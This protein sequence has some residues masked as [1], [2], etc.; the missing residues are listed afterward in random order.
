MFKKLGALGRFGEKLTPEEEEKVKSQA[1][2]YADLLK[3]GT[4]VDKDFRDS[5]IAPEYP[6]Y[7]SRVIAALDLDSELV[8]RISEKAR[9]EVTMKRSSEGSEWWGPHA[10]T[11]RCAVCG[12]DQSFT[13][14]DLGIDPLDDPEGV[15]VLPPSWIRIPVPPKLKESLPA[16]SDQLACGECVGQVMMSMEAGPDSR[17]YW[18]PSDP[19]ASFSLIDSA[20]PTH[21]AFWAPADIASFSKEMWPVPR[22]GSSKGPPEEP[23][24]VQIY[25]RDVLLAK[26]KDVV[27]KVEGLLEALEAAGLDI[28]IEAKSVRQA[29]SDLESF[30]T[31]DSDYEEEDTDF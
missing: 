1:E 27:S 21:K 30:E 13:V 25:K 14:K 16:L 19:M 22:E 9:R 29:I 7:K 2:Y 12:L 31:E 24:D 5:S 3:A 26:Y 18:K 20:S 6:V 10:F 28:P 15:S 17:A 11:F 4:F 8:S 23:T